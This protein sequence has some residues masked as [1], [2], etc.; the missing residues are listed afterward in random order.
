MGFVMS[1]ERFQKE[2]KAVV[3]AYAKATKRS[4]S[5]I[6]E[7]FYGKSTIFRR[8]IAGE[9]S[10]TIRQFY[11]VIDKFRDRWPPGAQWPGTGDGPNVVGPKGK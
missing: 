9:C 2:L 7:D 6:S 4:M 1:E 11:A 3:E 5:A 8:F 10:M